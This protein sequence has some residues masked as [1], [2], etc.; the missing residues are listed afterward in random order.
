[1]WVIRYF[2]RF[3]LIYQHLSIAQRVVNEM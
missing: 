3:R 1:L 2:W